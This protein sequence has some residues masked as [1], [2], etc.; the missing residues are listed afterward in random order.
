V[1]APLTGGGGNTGT[2]PS[3][4]WQYIGYVQIRTGEVWVSNL[5]SPYNSPNTYQPYRVT[6]AQLN[7]NGGALFHY[8]MVNHGNTTIF[9]DGWSEAFFQNTQSASGAVAF[10]AAPCSTAIAANAGGVAPYP[11]TAGNINDFQYARTGLPAGCS[12]TSPVAVFDINTFN[13]DT[14]GTPYVMLAYAKTPFSTGSANVWGS[15]TFFMSIL[16]SGMAGPTNYT[17]GQ[18]SGIGANPNSCGGLGPAYNPFNHL[19]D[20]IVAYAQV[21]PFIGMVVY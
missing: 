17:Y 9:I 8:K 13:Q 7:G 12:V 6:R 16:V 5:S 11:G 4:L 19:N 15:A 3:Q 14:G 2:I 1:V 21:I 10:I 20:P 18:L